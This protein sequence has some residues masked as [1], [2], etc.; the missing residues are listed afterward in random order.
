MPT[1]I[2]GL[3]AHVL[4]IH[5]LVVLAP[6]GALFTVLSAVWPAA[7][8]RI[9]IVSPITCAI[10]VIFTPITQN[11]GEWLKHKLEQNGGNKAIEK[12]A[13]LGETFLWY[14]L[15]LFVVSAAVW[16]MGRMA[17]SAARTADSEPS[18]SGGAASRG[19]TAT[20]ARPDSRTA[21]PV[22]V[23][24]AVAVVAVAMS[25]VVVWQ[26]YRIGDSGAHAAWD[27]VHKLK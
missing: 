20:I 13:D 8:H 6:L 16:W 19:G 1:L 22:W 7:R 21:V 18:G 14:A 11:A 23:T 10:V 2:S 9:G 26:V 3:P 24:Y 15:G 17:D 5:V 12:H 25:I 4:L 27:Y